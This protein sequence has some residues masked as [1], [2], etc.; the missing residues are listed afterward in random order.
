MGHTKEHVALLHNVACIL[1]ATKHTNQPEKP[2]FD[3][4]KR[5]RKEKNTLVFTNKKQKSAFVKVHIFWE[6]QNLTKPPS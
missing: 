4:Q 6:G 2:Q 3:V 1:T 5:E